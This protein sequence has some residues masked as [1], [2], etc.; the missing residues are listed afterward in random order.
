M[1]YGGRRFQSMCFY[2]NDKV[3]GVGACYKLRA[4]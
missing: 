1:A 3:G 2:E 4:T